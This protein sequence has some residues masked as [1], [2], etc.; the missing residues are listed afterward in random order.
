[1]TS[2]QTFMAGKDQQVAPKLDGLTPSRTSSIILAATLPMLPR[3]Y[4]TDPSGRP[5]LTDCQRSDP[6]KAVK[7]S[8]STMSEK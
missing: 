2:T 1:M 7:S 6:S 4:L 5:L 3:W 8:K